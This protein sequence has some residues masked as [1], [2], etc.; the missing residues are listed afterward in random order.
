MNIDTKYLI[1]WGVPGWILI[2]VVITYLLSISLVS[3]EVMSVMSPSLLAVGALLTVLG[4]PLGYL[5]NQ[6]HHFL[7]WVIFPGNW[8]KYFQTEVELDDFFFKTDHGPEMRERYSY[9]LSR[10]HELGGIATALSTSI[11]FIII[12]SL[13]TGWEKWSYLTTYLVFILIF[14]NI[15]I[16]FNRIYFSRNLEKYI[17]Y[18]L[19]ERSKQD[20]T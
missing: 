10:K 3:F 15:A 6:L 14:L 4:V 9:L 11:S 8:S 19:Y 12:D 18:F 17:K 5:L 2:S 13:R 7:T 1:R 16:I 20:N